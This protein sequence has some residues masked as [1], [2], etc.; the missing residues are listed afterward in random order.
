[1]KLGDIDTPSRVALRLTIVVMN[2]N[3]FGHER[4]ALAHKK[5]SAQHAVL[6][7]ADF[8]KIAEAGGGT[9]RRFTSADEVGELSE[10]LADLQQDGGLHVV[11]IAINPDVEL[12]VSAEIAR[13]LR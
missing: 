13:H 9:S 4:H 12:A 5:L 11:E 10:D 7:A 1:M 2:D 8:I 6:K 3:G